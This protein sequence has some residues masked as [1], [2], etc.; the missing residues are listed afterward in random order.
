[1]L[2]TNL[3]G[4]SKDLARFRVGFHNVFKGTQEDLL[5]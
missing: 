5:E 2:R 3:N 1:M 4:V